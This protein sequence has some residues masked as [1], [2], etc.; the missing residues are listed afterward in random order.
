ML[1]IT[2]DLIPNGQEDKARTMQT[3]TITNVGG[4]DV[5]GEYDCVL[6]DDVGIPLRRAH[7][8][9]WARLG[10]DAAALV[11]E[12]LSRMGYGANVHIITPTRTEGI[13]QGMREAADRIAQ[14]VIREM[15]DR[16]LEVNGRYPSRGE[17]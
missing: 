10:R 9:N 14:S 12:A 16:N 6:R 5:R 17:P 11:H 15:E 13:T 7:I 4:T 2:I 8:T 3:L 1:R